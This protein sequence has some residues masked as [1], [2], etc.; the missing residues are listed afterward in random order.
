MQSRVCGGCG[1]EARFFDGGGL[2]RMGTVKLGC[3]SVASGIRTG[4]FFWRWLHVKSVNNGRCSLA[5]SS[6]PK[7]PLDK[8]RLTRKHVQLRA[9][10]TSVE[11]AHAN[12][13]VVAQPSFTCM[14]P[15][16]SLASLPATEPSPA[17]GPSQERSSSPACDPYTIKVDKLEWQRFPRRQQGRGEDTGRP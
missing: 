9:E 7:A 4:R 1:K 6:T 15:S 11:N 2:G 8:R 10:Q 5:P 17:V 16:R 12:C 14:A 3:F 13:D